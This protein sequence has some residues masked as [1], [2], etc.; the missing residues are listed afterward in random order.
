MRLD[1]IDIN[2]VRPA[3]T[4]FQAR[5]GKDFM[6]VKISLILKIGNMQ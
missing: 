6:D 4:S 2:W 3:L 5:T 1:G